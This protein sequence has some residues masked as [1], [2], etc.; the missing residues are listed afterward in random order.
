ML[1]ER[2]ALEKKYA[3]LHAPLFAK[4]A[5][6]VSGEVDV[7]EKE[8]GVFEEKPGTPAAVG[9]DGAPPSLAVP[10]FWT[11]AML[12]HSTLAQ[13][14]EPADVPALQ[15]LTEVRCVDKEDYTG[16]TLEFAFAQPNPFFTNA[17]LSK[18][19]EVPNL[20]EEDEPVLQAVRGTEIA[21]LPKQNLCVAEKKMKPKGKARGG[22][23]VKQVK[24]ES[25]F[26]W[27]EALDVPED[28]GAMDEE[29]YEDLMTRVR[30]PLRFVGGERSGW[31]GFVGI[32]S[33]S[34]S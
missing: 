3:A 15:F 24:K 8:D 19:Y 27:F 10:D 25:F 18:S 2:K 14:V 21:W 20:I 9:E 30:R 13:M 34:L 11:K 5:S 4:R 26:N 17:V 28:P 33:V 22:V 23:V 16:F 12:S 29:E 32:C 1:E 31:V 6:V 7:E